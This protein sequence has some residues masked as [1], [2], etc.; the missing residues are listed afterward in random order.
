MLLSVKENVMC[1]GIKISKLL[2]YINEICAGN[3]LSRK[4][5]W[6]QNG[7]HEE[8]HTNKKYGMKKPVNSTFISIR[9]GIKNK[10]AIEQS[11]YINL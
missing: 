2:I 7:K 1:I 9:K 5:L 10:A 3:G 6:N 4:E 11:P 8:Y